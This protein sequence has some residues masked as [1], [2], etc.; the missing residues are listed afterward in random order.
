MK[1]MKTELHFSAAF[2]PHSFELA[3]V[4]NHTLEQ[5]LQLHCSEGKWMDQLPMLALLYNA[6]PQSWI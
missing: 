4:S 5:L 2:Y 3:E 1:E 6:M